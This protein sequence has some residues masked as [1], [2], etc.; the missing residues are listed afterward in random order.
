MTNYTPAGFGRAVQKKRETLGI[1]Q[2]EFGI[3]VGYK[4]GAGAGVSISRIE[5]GRTLPPV[6]R[7]EGIAKA[8]GLPLAELEEFATVETQAL[9][10]LTPTPLAKT[11]QKLSVRDRAE[12]LHGRIEQRKQRVES[13]GA[14]FT[15]AYEEASGKFYLP[16]MEF[17][18]TIEDAATPS[19]PTANTMKLPTDVRTPA[20]LAEIKVKMLNIELRYIVAGVTTGALAGAGIGTIRAYGTYQG[21]A[22]FGT[23]SNGMPNQLLH[24]IAL[25]NSVLAGIGGGTL[26]QGGGGIQGGKSALIATV[27]FSALTGALIGGVLADLRRRREVAKISAELDTIETELNDTLP[28]IKEL[29]AA[30]LQAT[31]I[32]DYIAVHATHAF[33]KWHRS[34]GEPPHTWDALSEEQ[35]TRLDELLEVAACQLAIVGLETGQF[36][37]LRDEELE[38]FTAETNAIITYAD[39]RV[40]TLV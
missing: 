11:P 12:A 38:Q 9:E 31:E 33:E 19:V 24:G 3:Q 35:R 39:D 21:Q 10:A 2:D 29:R 34:F 40:R 32:L 1:Q 20:G 26:A 28:G 17:A 14:D 13:L 4:A 16:L 37:D 18:Q 5:T 36:L 25:R 6:A 8:L 27:G 23:A 15:R 7:R 30:L 22:W